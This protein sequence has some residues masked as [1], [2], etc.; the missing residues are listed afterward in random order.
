MYNMAEGPEERSGK[1]PFPARGHDKRE[2]CGVAPT[3][4]S[5]RKPLESL[6]T[7]SEIAA[8]EASPRRYGGSR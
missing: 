7:D 5:R 3:R 1:G 8:E 6:K 2:G 4:K